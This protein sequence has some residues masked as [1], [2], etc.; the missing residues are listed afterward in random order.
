MF[1]DPYTNPKGWQEG[2]L[3]DAMIGKASNGFF[4]KPADYSDDGNAGIVCVGDVVNRKYSNIDNLRRANADKKQFEKYKVQYGDMLFCRS[5]LVKEGIAKASIIPK[6]C[7]EDI[8]FECH[9]IRITL[10]KTK[11]IPEYIQ[12]FS[13][14]DYFRGQMMDKSKT[15]TMTTIG[16]K[17]VVSGKIFIPSMELQEEF[18]KF[19]E[20]TDKSKFIGFKSQFIEMFSVEKGWPVAKLESLCDSI[21]RGPFGSA[22]K[23]SFFVD[24]GADTVK[25]YEQKNAIQRSATLGDSYVTQEKY[26]ELKRFECGPGDFIMS[27]SGTIGCLYQLPDDAEPGIINQALCKFHL[28]GKMLPEVFLTYMRN[29]VDQLETKGS[30]IKNIGAVSFIKNMEIA[31]PPIEEQEVFAEFIRQSDK[32]K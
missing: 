16:Q 28:N 14:T 27:C 18:V 29:S 25:V 10:D 26:K 5:S 2:T 3:Q 11:V 15:A 13:T 32:S 6:E 9:V 19:A 24:K 31:L 1:G 23:V 21:V 22:L 8:L 4:A 7:S 20:Q 30:A 17:D 12:A